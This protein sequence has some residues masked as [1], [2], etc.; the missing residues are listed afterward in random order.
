MKPSSIALS[1]PALI[2]AGLVPMIW[3][4]PGV[5]KSDVVA[6]VAK[7]MN[8]ELRD[9]RLTLFDPV[10]LKGFPDKDVD[11]QQMRFLPPSFLPPM[12]VKGKPNKTKGI[13]FL[14]E[15]VSAERSVQAA[16][17]QLIL[18]RS[19][20]EYTLPDGW[21]VVAAGNRASDRALVNAMPSALA[22][23]F[24]HIDYDVSHDDFCEWAIKHGD[25]DSLLLA[26][27]RFR[28]GLLHDFKPA[29]NP[30]SF[31][32]PRSW[33]FVNR[34]LK[35]NSLHPSDE[36][37]LVAGTVGEGAASELV[38]FMRV[39]RDLPD[40][41]AILADPDKH[42]VPDGKPSVMYAL[43]TALGA[44]VTVPLF[45]NAVKYVERWSPEFQVL[46]MR[47]AARRDTAFTTQA[48]F[49]K[50]AVANSELLGAT[51]R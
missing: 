28:P 25:I 11:T 26:F 21:H 44:K 40:I 33:M 24:V 29:E 48:S 43:A 12:K 9:V 47:D 1:I 17:Y 42:K 32:S 15:L 14:D 7:A 39:Y 18:N 36:H 2:S 20:G 34:L 19:I 16:A 5:G 46:F 13:L 49:V 37:A 38:A 22:N 3:G 8:A 51:R 35:T 4:S 45:A 6:Q 50:W 23:R 30:R 41:D 31:P 27:L 10:D